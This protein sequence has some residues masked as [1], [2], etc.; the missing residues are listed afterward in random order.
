MKLAVCFYAFLALIPMLACK[1]IDAAS[2][3]KDDPTCL[4]IRGALAIGQDTTSASVAVVDRCLQKLSSDVL[5]SVESPA[6]C[7]Q[8][9]QLQQVSQECEK[10][11][12]A[13][14]KK[15]KD[16]I[17]KALGTTAHARLAAFIGAEFRQAKNASAFRAEIKAET[18]L[19]PR[20]I[21]PK[22]QVV[23]FYWAANIVPFEADRDL[24][25]WS[26]DDKYMQIAAKAADGN[27]VVH[28]GQLA[29]TSMK[30]FVLERKHSESGQRHA[31]TPNPVGRAFADL[32][33]DY[34]AK[35]AD[36]IPFE[37]KEKLAQGDVRGYGRVF[38]EVVSR[39]IG[40]NRGIFTQKELFDLADENINLADSELASLYKRVPA[41]TAANLHDTAADVTSLLLV[42]G[43]MSQLG[44]SKVKTPRIN[45][46]NGCILNPNVWP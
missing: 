46:A 20:I 41:D 16:D 3:V 18:G 7:R 1:T 9:L 17:V 45:L 5:F 29:E 23:F 31:K 33:L 32:A 36:S 25:V 22:E 4:E 14:I 24:V 42:G 21:D 11:T 44:I 27:L 35:N 15:A 2:Y 26:I 13:N 30:D 19:D 12:I 34:A 8:G 38:Q 28:S 10:Q 6:S 40:E 43:Y 37:L 39:Q